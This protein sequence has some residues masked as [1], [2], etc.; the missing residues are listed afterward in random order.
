MRQSGW[1][2]KMLKDYTI[3]Q[4]PSSKSADTMLKHYLKI[5]GFLKEIMKPLIFLNE[6]RRGSTYNTSFNSSLGVFKKY[7]N[8]FLKPLLPKKYDFIQLSNIYDIISYL[9]GSYSSWCILHNV[10]SRGQREWCNAHT[11][12]LIT[13]YLKTIILSY[14]RDFYKVKGE[15]KKRTA[16]TKLTE[17]RFKAKQM[18][19]KKR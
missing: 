7:D 18:P 19:K 12:K 16:Y 15:K 11:V 17:L 9:R 3:V 6:F 5:P 1:F 14:E 8:F 10:P 2:K 13:P 4:R